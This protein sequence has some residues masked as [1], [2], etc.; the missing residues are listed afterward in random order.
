M[1][2]QQRTQ[3]LKSIAQE[4]TNLQVKVRTLL[5]QEDPQQQNTVWQK[6]A[7]SLSAKKA[8]AMLKYIKKSRAASAQRFQK[9]RA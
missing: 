8:D 7:G 1:T 6:T 4:L 9:S 5:V 3:Q 2:V